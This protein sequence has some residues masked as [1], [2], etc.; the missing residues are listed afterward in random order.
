MKALVYR[1]S[2]PLYL[3]SRTLGKIQPRRF[4][5]RLAPVG[6]RQIPLP[7]N[8]RGWVLLENRLCGICGS[9]LGLLRGMESFLLEP[10]ASFPAVLGHEIAAMVVEAPNNS[11]WN[12]GDRVVV[13][14]LL[15]CT[16]RGAPPC[17]FCSQGS[18]N[19]CESFTAGNLAA[20]PVIG[21]NSSLGGGMAEF[22]VAPPAR[23]IRIPDSLTDEKAVLADSL[24]SALQPI[25]DHFPQ[26]DQ[27]VVIFGA[28]ILGQHAIRIL[29]ALGS[30][31]RLAVVARH[32]FQQELARNGGADLVLKSPNRGELGKAVGAKFLPTTLGGGNLEGGADLVFD[33][34]ASRS[35]LQEALLALRARGKY[36]MVGT[37][38]SI[39]PVDFS[40]LW[41]RELRV[42]G[43]SCY[44]FG[45]YEG[46]R[47]RTYQMAIDM[48]AKGYPTEGLLTHTYS[49]S[50]FASAFKTAFNK[51]RFKSVKVAIDLRKTANRNSASM[52]AHKF[53]AGIS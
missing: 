4:F 34:V 5:P 52:A 6:L 40:S 36:I 17:R 21:Y 12:R 1:R 30:R 49:L 31:A 44:A 2:A 42:T 39:G 20:G 26:D 43:S 11:E 10:Y 50:K 28:G 3:L 9:D 22:M 46:Q 47:V 53:D 33:F 24:A 45:N 48:L 7:R 27:T 15:S 25:L 16:E 18:Y 38:G 35:S 41:F 37:A 29:R 8:E 14:P 32:P 23:L 51:S 13:E 19:L